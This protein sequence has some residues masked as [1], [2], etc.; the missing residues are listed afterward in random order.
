MAG[1]MRE[2]MT[3]AQREAKRREHRRYYARTAF[4]YKPRPW[5]DDE[6]RVV[7]AHDVPDSELSERIGRSM[8]AISNRRWR[9]RKEA[10]EAGFHG[11]R[12]HA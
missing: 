1:R 3:M 9:L 12:E 2:D 4:L 7:L 5:S 8:K 6:D 10:D 11:R